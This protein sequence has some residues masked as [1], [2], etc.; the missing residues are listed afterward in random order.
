F[1]A[2]GIKNSA[3]LSCFI[4]HTLQNADPA[5]GLVA[6]SAK[7][8]VGCIGANDRDRLVFGP[9]ERKQMIL[10]LEQDDRFLRRFQCQL[11]MLGAVGDSVGVVGIDKRFFE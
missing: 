9:I 11:L 5:T 10:I 7:M 8:Y 3:S 4:F 6:V 1:A 2:F